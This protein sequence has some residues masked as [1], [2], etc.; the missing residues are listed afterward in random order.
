MTLP[1]TA[2]AFDYDLPPERI[3]QR[4]LSD[5]AASKLLALDRRTGAIR[6]HIYR[7]LPTLLSPGDVLVVNTSRVVPARLRGHRSNGAPAE[8]LLLRAEPGGTWLALGHPGGKLK[9]GRHVIFGPDA[10]VE[11]VAMLGGGLR[12]LRWVGTLS[13]EAAM[14]RY[15]E[16][17]LPPYIRR[18]PAPGDA[19]RYQTVYADVPGSAAAPTAGLHLTPALLDAVRERG[20][21]I[22]RLTLHIG[23]GTFKPVTTDDLDRH[24]MHEEEY[25]L[26]PDQASLV[27]ERRAAGGA[28]WAVGTTVAR[29]LETL[30][31]PDGTVAAGAGTTRLF[32]RPPYEF[33]LIDRLLTNF[34]LPRSTLLMLVA[35]F[36]GYEHVMQAYDQAV[37]AE[38]RFYS[39]GDAM[40]VV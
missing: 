15:G 18:A 4:P 24:V 13:A 11:V 36:G 31:R 9:P 34:H 7:D 26:T 3:A 27:S 16:T 39:Y 6:H 35:A 30:A 23:L 2:A 28:C 25:V 1:R 8:I 20:V 17:P 21:A 32:I 10:E 38:Y 22:A 40:A 14:E 33:R 12:R 5:R 29:V 37:R 19:E